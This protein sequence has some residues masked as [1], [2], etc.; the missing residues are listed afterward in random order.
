MKKLPLNNGLVALVD[1]A[2]YPALAAHKWNVNSDGYVMRTAPHPTNPGR[3]TTI[4]MHRAIMGC[5]LGDGVRVDHR[6]VNTLNCQRGNLRIATHMQNMQNK[7]AYRNNASGFKGVFLD[8]R[9]GRWQAAI[10]SRGRRIH[11]GM[12]DSPRSCASSLL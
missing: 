6:D 2:D 1:D 8:K 7:P 4:Y 12:S 11:L 9:S 10:M 3:K 5:T